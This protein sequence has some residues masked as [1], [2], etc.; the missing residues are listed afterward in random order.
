MKY[1]IIRRLNEPFPD[2]QSPRQHLIDTV[3]VSL[4]VAA[5]LYF[6]RPFGLEQMP[7]GIGLAALSFGAIS[8]CCSLSFD[9]F[10]R[11]VLLLQSDVPTWTLWKWLLLA[12]TMVCWIAIGNYSLLVFVYPQALQWEL[13]IGI[14]RG[15]LLV[16]IVPI[17][18]S[19]LLIQLR[20][21]K[22]NQEEARLLTPN[23]ISVAGSSAQGKVHC[24]GDRVIEFD[25]S[26]G[27]ALCLH[28]SQI[29]FIEAMQNY[30][31][32]HHSNGE[33]LDEK[34]KTVIRS[35]ISKAEVTLADSSVM[36]CH[37]SYLVN[38][39]AVAEVKGNAQG[40][41]LSING[42]EDFRV[43]VSRR[44]IS[45]FKKRMNSR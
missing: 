29:C 6:F 44:Y 35:T 32:V 9:W 26:S 15:T 11:H 25:V 5:F 31:S 18:V 14:L 34:S 8:F 41:K 37:R 24:V 42:I 7:M 39:D 21:I 13:F 33:L 27:E 2:R 3:C 36:R 20:A 38:L 22:R 16:G 23:M 40:L 12:T 30:L 4:F 45:E 10:V 17:I 43:P 19:G 1:T 28:E